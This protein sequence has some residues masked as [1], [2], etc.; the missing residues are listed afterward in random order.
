MVEK[1]DFT[2]TVNKTRGLQQW[3]TSPTGERGR[4]IDVYGFGVDG[5]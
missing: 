3:M 1:D 2:Q 5:T 4:D